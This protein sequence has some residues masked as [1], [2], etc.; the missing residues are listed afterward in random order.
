MVASHS[1]C[2]NLKKAHSLVE[3]AYDAGVCFTDVADFLFNQC[4]KLAYQNF[5]G[6][7]GHQTK[8]ALVHSWGF[9]LAR[10]SG[11]LIRSNEVIDWQEENMP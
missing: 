1:T 5:L 7:F 6:Y 3:R 9:L 4:S 8:W 11:K 2:A 10:F